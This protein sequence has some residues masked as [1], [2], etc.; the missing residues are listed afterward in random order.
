MPRILTLLLS[1]LRTRRPDVSIG[2]QIRS[3]AG[4]VGV[5]LAAHIT[6]MVVFEGLTPGEA[7]W[8]TITTLTTVGY[9][10]YSAASTLGRVSTIVF[11][12]LGAV[13]VAARLGT[14]VIEYYIDRRT[15]MSNGSWRW[16]MRDHIVIVNSP[17]TGAVRYLERL[18]RK[19]RD[20]PD[21]GQRQVQLLSQAF[22]EGLPDSLVNLGLVHYNGTG[23]DLR[24]LEAV[25]VQH[26]THVVV[27]A[28]DDD[29]VRSDSL[30]FDVLHR[31][32]EL[33]SGA[34]L[35]V[36]TVDDDNR[37]RFRQFGAHTIIR[38]LR[39]Y[40]EAMV[41]SIAAPGSEEVLEDLL[42]SHGSITRRYD[43]RVTGWVWQ[44][45]VFEVMTHGWGTAMAYVDAG[46]NVIVNPAPTTVVD[47]YGLLLAVPANNIPTRT[48]VVDR[49]GVVAAAR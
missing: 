13:W 15:R 32:R 4:L 7:T 34:R 47:G 49:F 22:P 21:L 37:L 5:L 3:T 23:H 2:R 10:D 17:R 33:Y 48:E 38:P 16:N 43:L 8:L 11:M 9:G 12:Y 44:D 28:P 26:A 35:I 40:P 20:D 41:Q 30:N 31:M 1:A 24:S 19:L 39:A 29:D 6:A 36:E 46:A 18:L 42:T 45:L 25:N 14:L 27:L